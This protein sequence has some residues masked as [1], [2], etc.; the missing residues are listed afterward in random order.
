MEEMLDPVVE[1]RS[2][3]QQLSDLL[4]SGER[5]PVRR[6]VAGLEPLDTVHVVSQ[7]RDEE[8]AKLLQVLHPEDAAEVLEHIPD[9]QAGDALESI[10]P[11]QAARILGEMPSDDRADLLNEIADED[12]EAILARMEPEQARELRELASYPEDTAGGL[13]IHEYVRFPSDTTVGEVIDHLHAE[14]ETYKSYDVQYTYVNDD[15]G[16]LV[17]V[18]PVRELLFASRRTPIEELMV[19][20]PKS[21]R[22]AATVQELVGFFGENRFY[23]VPV[24]DEA[25]VLRGVLRA[26]AV[27]SAVAERSEELFRAAQGIVGGEE[28]RSMPLLV[29]SRRR[30]SWLSV[31]ILLN[32]LAASVIALHQETLEAVIALAVFLPIISDM[33]GCSGSQAVA[34]SM[35]ELTLG[36]TR[37]TDVGRV[38]LQEAWVGVLN[39]LA[40]GVLIA[41]VAWLWPGNP[42]LGLVVGGA[43]ALNTVV[44]VCIGGAVPLVLRRLGR[45]PA[46]ASG[47][48]LTTVTD[49]CGFFLVLSLASLLLE[50]LA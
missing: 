23:G 48:I 17:G 39:G 33:S 15:R 36:V 12:A 43:L 4:E 20:D 42:W 22:V 31:N 40:L 24:V 25:G 1:P 47:P 38:L 35:R 21:V 14:S 8:R 50:R 5:R 46:L 28:L 6:F 10:H 18:L 11:A 30:L 49:M 32:V 45:D 2:L 7:L 29:R 27:E 19:R 9:V 37:P 3:A 16:R 41:G 34:V 26:R 44:A 13:M